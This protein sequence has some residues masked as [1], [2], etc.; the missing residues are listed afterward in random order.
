M[1][2]AWVIV[3]FAAACGGGGGNTPDAALPDGDGGV[4]PDADPMVDTDGDGA[5][6][7]VDVCP[8]IADPAQ[9][10]LDGDHIG[11]MCDPVESTTIQHT[12]ISSDFRLAVRG[13][14]AGANFRYG[15][16][17][18]TCQSAALSV[19]PGGVSLADSNT[20]TWPRDRTGD[21]YRARIACCGR[22]ARAG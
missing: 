16:Q 20:D 19:G 9:V 12:S 6:D 2:F 3:L 21:G 5:F 13:D 10:D 1:K 4:V 7:N 15:C 8:T 18:G 14:T 17:T 11:W 22:S